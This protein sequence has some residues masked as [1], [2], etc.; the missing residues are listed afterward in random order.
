MIRL[1]GRAPR[2][3]HIPTLVVNDPGLQVYVLTLSPEE[4]T[5]LTVS[6][7]LG[8]ESHQVMRP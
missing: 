6:R 7:D 3:K 5:Q 8:R 4:N 2:G 1:V